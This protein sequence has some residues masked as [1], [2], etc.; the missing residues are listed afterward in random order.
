VKFLRNLI[1]QPVTDIVNYCH[2][3]KGA[4]KTG[5]ARAKV[6]ITFSVASRDVYK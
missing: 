3:R 6:H 4:T 2:F 1:K 5:S